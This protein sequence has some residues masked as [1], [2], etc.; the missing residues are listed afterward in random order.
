MVKHPGGWVS[1]MKSGVG[2][3]LHC[4]YTHWNYTMQL[5]YMDHMLMLESHVPDNC[6]PLQAKETHDA[7]KGMFAFPCTMWVF[8]LSFKTRS[9]I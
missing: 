7:I 4:K 9:D 6:R 8:L 5:S 2:K 3:W 1:S